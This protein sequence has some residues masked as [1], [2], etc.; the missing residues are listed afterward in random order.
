MNQVSAPIIVSGAPRSGTT[1]TQELLSSHGRIRIHGQ[2]GMW[3]HVW[4]WYRKL[5][6]AGDEAAKASANI[7][8]TAH[9]GGS[10]ETRCRAIAGRLWRDFISGHAENRPRWGWRAPW[11]C[12][13]RTQ[14]RQAE[15][16]WGDARWIVC[17]RD[18]FRAWQSQRGTY[19]PKL[20][21]DE[22]IRRWI[23]IVEFL[24]YC[25]PNRLFVVRLDLWSEATAKRRKRHIAELFERIGEPVDSDVARF[26]DR[27]PKIHHRRRHADLDADARRRVERAFPE[28]PALMHSVGYRDPTSS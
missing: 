8:L 20:S 6:E 13:N 7:G 22:S 19:D 10:D 12:A 2:S 27:W 25:D 3:E 17:M 1:F 15:D 16:L 5:V 4:Q 23:K 18:P 28:L 24:G 26:V 14:V 9:Y 21:L 11:M